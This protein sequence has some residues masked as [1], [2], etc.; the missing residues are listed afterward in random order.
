MTDRTPTIDELMMVIGEITDFFSNAAESELRG[1]P[2]A[3]YDI[4]LADSLN[5]PAWFACAARVAMMRPT[6]RN[7]LARRS[8]P[9]APPYR[10]SAK[11]A[12]PDS[13]AGRLCCEP[14]ARER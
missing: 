2:V 1:V 3:T 5:Y 9:I 13:L 7:D 14:S 10:P 6:A 11:P 8:A 4:D 12:L